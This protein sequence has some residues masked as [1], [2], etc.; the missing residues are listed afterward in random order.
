MQFWD[1]SEDARRDGSKLENSFSE[2]IPLCKLAASLEPGLDLVKLCR[3]RKKG[4]GRRMPHD[5]P[6]EKLKP[7]CPEWQLTWRSTKG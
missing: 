1:L 3:E 2:A 7:P 4:E 5:A 6:Y